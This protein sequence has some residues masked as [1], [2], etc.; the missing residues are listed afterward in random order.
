M[1]LIAN[2][3]VLRVAKICFR[4][5]TNKILKKTMV[6]KLVGICGG[7]WEQNRVEIFYI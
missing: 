5:T 7:K 4:G 6:E 3:G 1:Q 2:Q